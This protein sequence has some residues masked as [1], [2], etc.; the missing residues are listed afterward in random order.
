MIHATP[1]ETRK[2]LAFLEKKFGE[3]SVDANSMMDTR[4]M[5][6]G[7]AWTI[8]S[9][10]K[11]CIID[12]HEFID[13]LLLD[14]GMD[15]CNSTKTPAPQEE[16]RPHNVPGAQHPQYMKIVG[17]IGWL[18]AV[19]RPDIAFAFKEVARHGH[20][21]G[22]VHMAYAKRIIRFLKGTRNNVLT[23]RGAINGGNINL[24]GYSDASY[25]WA[26][27]NRRRCTSGVVLTMN[28][29]VIHA[30]SVT[31]KNTATSSCEAELYAAFSTATWIYHFRSVLAFMGIVTD[32][33]TPMYV[34]SLSAKALL[35]NASPGKRLK[36]VDVRF[37]KIRE[38]VDDGM[39]TLRYE[40][41][42]TLIAD[43]LTK[44]LAFELYSFHAQRLLGGTIKPT[45]SLGLSNIHSRQHLE[46][47]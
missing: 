26:E 44:P 3:D 4:S 40:P 38:L 32:K 6:V 39:L 27:F 10:A 16:L 33:P 18:T 20:C 14:T 7:A 31:Q 15:D 23:L 46:E 45:L 22:E 47:V 8:D 21:N 9:K 35:K 30:E 1:Q 42:N 19:S 12:Q 24:E 41:T 2:L 34:D 11:T 25:A 28:G 13:K 17:S 37:W 36:H 29:C 5:Y 43:L